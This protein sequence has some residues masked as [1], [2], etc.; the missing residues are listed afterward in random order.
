M[1]CFRKRHFMLKA[2][3]SSQVNINGCCETIDE[4]WQI[5]FG[6]SLYVRL[7]CQTGTGREGGGG[8]GT[9]E[10]EANYF[11]Y[12]LHGYYSEISSENFLIFWLCTTFISNYFQRKLVWRVQNLEVNFFADPRVTET[13][14]IG[15][16]RYPP[17][18]SFDCFLLLPTTRVQRLTSMLP[19][20]NK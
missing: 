13:L 20:G 16:K 19:K 7:A 6:R 18:S 17:P 9:G 14:R 11:G 5:Y 10:E 12:S 4:N 3:F 1:L 8:G 2:S 15:L